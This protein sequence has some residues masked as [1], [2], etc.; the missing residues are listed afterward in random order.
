M[1]APLH[2]L[3]F[4]SRRVSFSLLRREK[5]LSFFE[6]IVFTYLLTFGI[7]VIPIFLGQGLLSAFNS[8]MMQL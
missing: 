4:L 6:I 7:F 2:L 8:D 3:N 1:L 5:L